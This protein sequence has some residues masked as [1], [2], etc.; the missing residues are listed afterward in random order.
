MYKIYKNTN[1][2]KI[3]HKEKTRNLKKKNPIVKNMRQIF[4]K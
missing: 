4:Q 2:K 1:S 3:I